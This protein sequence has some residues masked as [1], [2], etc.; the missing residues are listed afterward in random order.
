[1]QGGGGG[2]DG[3]VVNWTRVPVDV[4]GW[5]VGFD[6][7][8]VGRSIGER[9]EG[10]GDNRVGISAV[11]VSPDGIQSFWGAGEVVVRGE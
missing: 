10:E 3:I 7:E 4:E 1:M 11:G 5:G 6:L 9:S 2:A 8:S